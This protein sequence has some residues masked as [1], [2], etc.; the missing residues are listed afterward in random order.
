VVYHLIGEK[1]PAGLVGDGCALGDGARWLW[2]VIHGYCG[3]AKTFSW[4]WA[5]QTAE[6]RGSSY[7]ATRILVDYFMKRGLDE[8]WIEGCLPL[9]A[10][11]KRVHLLME[12][13]H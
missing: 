6:R 3:T 7:D 8:G 4:G 10:L 12:D 11:S 2:K 9:P 1:M 5:L 13:S